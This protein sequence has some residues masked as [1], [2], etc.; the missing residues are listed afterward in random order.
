[1]SGNRNFEGRIN[2]LVRA[3]YLASPPLVVAYALAGRVDV[4]LQNDPLGVDTTER[5]FISGTSGHSPE[6]IAAVVK[7][8]VRSEMFQKQYAEVFRGRRTAGTASRFRPADLYDWSDRST[9]IRKP[10]YFENMVDP[11]PS[12]HDFDGLRV[13]AMLGDSVTTDHISPAGNIPGQPGGQVSDRAGSEAR[14]FQF[15]RGAARQSRS[16]GARNAGEYSS[17][18]PARSRHRRR[19]DPYIP[20]GEKMFIYDASVRYQQEASRS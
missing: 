11:K 3:N 16:D 13:L 7:R 5:T 17:S 18:Q 6:E 10:P 14:R 12:V 9:Y 4:D 20:T 1:M 2:S 15:L 19:L 8:S